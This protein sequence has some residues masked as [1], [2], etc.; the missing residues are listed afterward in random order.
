[1]LRGVL[2]AYGIWWAVT[3]IIKWIFILGWPLLI[4]MG[5]AK[6]FGG[7]PEKWSEATK[8]TLTI[9]SLCISVP[10]YLVYRRTQKP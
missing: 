10:L 7:D 5:V 4:F 8:T 6:L 1:M 2:E 9:I 3:R